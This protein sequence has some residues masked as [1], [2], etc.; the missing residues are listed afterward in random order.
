MT[1]P[2]VLDKP[3]VENDQRKK[4]KQDSTIIHHQTMQ[5]RT[6][7]QEIRKPQDEA[8]LVNNLYGTN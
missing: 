7:A 6:K 5:T 3:Q 8:G 2:G 4:M 1:I